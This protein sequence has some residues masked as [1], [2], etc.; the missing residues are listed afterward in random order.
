MNDVVA[1]L[2]KN[3]GL[4]TFIWVAILLQWG[5]LFDKDGKTNANIKIHSEIYKNYY[6][7]S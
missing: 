2:P 7:R 4:G 1:S 6:E 5:D 3:V